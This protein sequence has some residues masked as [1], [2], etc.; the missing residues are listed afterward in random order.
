MAFLPP[1]GPQ[2]PQWPQWPQWPQGPQGPQGFQGLQAP[3]SPPPQ[4]VP[5]QPITAF[6][7]DPGA[8]SGCLF[9][10]TYIWLANGQNFWL[11]PVFVGRNSVS[12]FRW[13]GWFWM[14]SGV[15]LRQINSFTCF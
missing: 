12:G 13:N 11:F 9:R 4:F 10:N 5:Q 8:I 15:D 6:A 2:G 3:T 14:Y 7:V 1:L